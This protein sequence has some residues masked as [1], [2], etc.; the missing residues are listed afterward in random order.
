MKIGAMQVRAASGTVERGHCRLLAMATM[1]SLRP[2]TA[3]TDASR[4]DWGIP[5]H[6]HLLLME[7]L[8]YVLLPEF[9]DE[10]DIPSG[11]LNQGSIAWLMLK[12]L[13]DQRYCLQL[14]EAIF[15]YAASSPLTLS[16]AVRLNKTPDETRQLL[17]GSL[18]EL[19]F[20]RILWDWRN[21]LGL[22]AEDLTAAAE[23]PYVPEFHPGPHQ[24]APRSK[25]GRRQAKRKR[26]YLGPIRGMA[27]YTPC[28]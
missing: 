22:S 4:Q 12:I 8:E 7:F 6:W 25:A 27:E 13:A 20:P 5:L 11:R 1:R 21:E 14:R 24:V 9:A 10:F 16:H 18:E 17:R 19:P 15:L 26:I 28:L 23:A 2:W 3:S